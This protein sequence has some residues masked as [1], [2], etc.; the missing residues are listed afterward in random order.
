[1]AFKGISNFEHEEKVGR[2]YAALKI[3]FLSYLPISDHIPDHTRLFDRVFLQLFI[4]KVDDLKESEILWLEPVDI[5]VKSLHSLL[6][7]ICKVIE[8][9]DTN[10]DA[11]AYG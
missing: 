1:M 4:V 10:D 6:F 5:D 9:L 8:R 7:D 11:V 2:F 3:F